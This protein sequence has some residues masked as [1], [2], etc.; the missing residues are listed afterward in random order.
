M[1]LPAIQELKLLGEQTWPVAISIYLPTARKGPETLQSHTRL[2]N[3]LRSAEEKL[4]TLGIKD[5]QISRLLSPARALVNDYEFWQHQNEGLAVFLSPQGMQTYSLPV[6]VDESMLV[7]PRFYIKPLIALYAENGRFWVLCLTL[8]SV[9]LF[10][11]T[12][13]TIE[14]VQLRSVPGS[15]DEAL[16]YDD[17]Q[18]GH[19]LGPGSQGRRAGQSPVFHG[20]GADAQD[21]QDRKTEIRRFFQMVDSGVYD[22]IGKS[23]APLVIAAIGHLHSI[24]QDVNSYPHLIESGVLENP[25]QMEPDDLLSKAWAAVELVFSQNERAAAETYFELKNRGRASG[26][27]Q[28]VIQAAADGRV[29]CLFVPL[30]EQRWGVYDMASRHISLRRKA[31]SGAEDLFDLA[32]MHTLVNGGKVFAVT[33]DHMPDKSSL[34]AVFRY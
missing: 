24:Y 27:L 6:H 2:R 29:D 19:H 12:R 3:L 25:E 23:N 7:N 16:R 31:Q 5:E 17:S 15:L 33:R 4:T 32:A 14:E 1:N 18:R 28:E 11:A 10:R 34:A 20:H 30:N 9:K 13:Y 8:K 22:V 26:R 21:I